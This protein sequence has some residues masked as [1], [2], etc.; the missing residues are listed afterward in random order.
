MGNLLP[1][2]FQPPGVTGM[3]ELEEGDRG[4]VW[5][6]D[7]RGECVR[8]VGWGAAVPQRILKCF[9]ASAT[10]GRIFGRGGQRVGEQIPGNS[11]V[12]YQEVNV[13]VPIL[14]SGGER[15]K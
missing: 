13:P 7:V 6:R 4:V 5:C 10:V 3:K 9:Y 8:E 11:G 12:I 15:Q 14:H 2:F 1:L